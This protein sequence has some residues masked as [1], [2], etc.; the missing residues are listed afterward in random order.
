[1]KAQKFLESGSQLKT[2][3][4]LLAAMLKHAG[5]DAELAMAMWENGLSG[6]GLFR[7]AQICKDNGHN[8]KNLCWGSM[9]TEWFDGDVSEL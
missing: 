4:E 2:S 7:L 1:M 9:G 8:P 3:P 5:G 6:I